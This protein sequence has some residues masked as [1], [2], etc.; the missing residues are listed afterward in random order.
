MSDK[1]E[2]PCKAVLA[3]A[4]PR[5]DDVPVVPHSIYTRKEKWLI[6][7]M[8]ALAGF[9]SPLPANIYFPALPTLTHA[10]AQTP[11]SMNQTITIYLIF[12]GLSPMLWGPLS[13]SMAG[14]LPYSPACLSC[15]SASTIALGAGVIG[16]IATREERG[17]YFGM[18]NLGP[19]L[20]PCIAPAAGGALSQ[21]LGWRSIFWFIV[22]TVD[23]CLLFIALFLPETLCAIAGNGSVP[24]PRYLRPILPIVGSKRPPLP[25]TNPDSSA[26]VEVATAPKPRLLINPIPLFPYPDV[27]VLLTFTGTI[28]ACNYTITATISTL[29]GKLLDA[30]YARIKAK[31]SGAGDEGEGPQGDF[32]TEHAHLRLM[33]LY[34]VLFVASVLAWGWTLYF[35]THIG[36]PLLLGVSRSSGATTCTNLVRCSLAA[37]L[38][39]VIERMEGS[40]GYGWTYT[41][42]AGIC[43]M[44]LPLMYLEMRM[45]PWWRGRRR[46]EAIVWISMY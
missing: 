27:L 33:P 44:L 35:R 22:I 43:A 8:V 31:T 16:D 2:P 32:T 13:T 29:T 45:G 34:L 4:T 28:Y 26:E 20:A 37:V 24:V 25:P 10:F 6:V 14:A 12:Q 36:V 30:D 7:A 3:P 38:A 18:F 40:W 5:Q 15:G 19:M 39:A 23:V 1:Q 21:G 42:W 17:G 11:S 46:G 41:F 9:Y